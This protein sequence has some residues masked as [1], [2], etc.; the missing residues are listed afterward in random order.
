VERSNDSAAPHLFLHKYHFRRIAMKPHYVFAIVKRCAA[1]IPHTL[2]I[3]LLAVVVAGIPGLAETLQFDRTQ[4]EAGQLWR[5]ATGHLTH[6]NFEHLQ[7]DLLMF[8]VLGTI[9]ELRNPRQMRWC[10]A[11]AAAAVSALVFVAFPSVAAYR[12]L[13]G[14]DT[15]LFTLLALALLK[16]ARRDHHKFLAFTTTA[17]LIGFIAKTSYEAVTGHAFFVN[18]DAAGFSLLVWD[19]VVAGAVGVF[20]VYGA[21]FVADARGFALGTMP[22]RAPGAGPAG[23]RVGMGMSQCHVRLHECTKLRRISD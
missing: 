4:I 9:C 1:R 2:A 3:T 12:G 5:F 19:H 18:Q 20:T 15:A 6:W 11:I 8:A 23:C 7:W 14:I 17:L 10:V 13:S 22:T 16:D 21:K